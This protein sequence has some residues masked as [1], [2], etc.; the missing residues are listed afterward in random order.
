M[1]RGN[2]RVEVFGRGMAWLDTGTYDGLLEAANFVSI[3]QRRQGLYIS[4]IEE[5]AYRMGYI[6]K[7]KLLELAAYMEKTTYGQYL[8]RVA[9]EII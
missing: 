3:I 2:L 1:Q 7:N 5:I 6:S 4:C 9:E 8:K